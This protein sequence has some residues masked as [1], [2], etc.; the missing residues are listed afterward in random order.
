MSTPAPRVP[1]ILV[2]DDDH[3]SAEL[4][5]TALTARGYSVALAHDGDEALRAVEALRPHLVL[6][7]VMMPGRSGWDV[8]RVIKQHP[9]YAGRVRVVI[10]TALGGWS[11]MQEALRTGADDYVTKPVDLRA[12]GRCVERNLAVLE[13]AI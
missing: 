1:A 13:R 5:R 11:D 10:L 6:L 3:D 7:D 8:C 12:L 9:E 4:L 2:V